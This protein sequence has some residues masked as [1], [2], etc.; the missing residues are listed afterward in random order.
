MSEVRA[1]VPACF[2]DACVPVCSHCSNSRLVPARAGVRLSVMC[3]WVRRRVCVCAVVWEYGCMGVRLC[4]R[5][6]R[7]GASLY[8][9]IGIRST[10]HI[11]S[12]VVEFVVD[13]F[14]LGLEERREPTRPVA[15]PDC[16]FDCEF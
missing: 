12:M 6:R 9:S 5:V 1:L 10:V 16:E 14:G 3:V 7:A 8:E 15:T 4:G 13:V 11:R 2:L